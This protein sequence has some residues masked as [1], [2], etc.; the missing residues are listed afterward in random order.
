MKIFLIEDD[1]DD[2]ELLEEALKAQDL[3]YNIDLAKD[4]SAAIAYLKT[5]TASPDVI[6]LDFNLPKIH[7]REVLIQIKAAAVF[8]NV[9]IL[10]LTT[11]SAKEDIEFS[12]KHGANKYLI[13]PTSIKQ[14]KETVDTIVELA[15]IKD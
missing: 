3:K 12:Y 14:I 11:S 9:P 1:S 13:K 8:K 10:I 6:V 7:G 5:C 2:V 4:G 15:E